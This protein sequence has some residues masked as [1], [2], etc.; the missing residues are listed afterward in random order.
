MRIDCFASSSSGNLYRVEDGKTTLL[1]ECGLPLQKIKQALNFRLSEIKSCLLSHS[2]ADHSRAALYLMRSG[3]DCYMSQETA[4]ALGV[5][6][7]HRL[8]VME[9]FFTTRIGTWD[10]VAFDTQHDCPGSLGFL[11]ASKAGK[12]LF[13]TDSYYCRYRFKGLTNIMIE[14]NYSRDTLSPDVHP[15]VKKRLLS[16]HM[17]LE[18][19][20][21]FFS[22][23]DLS[24]VREIILIHLSEGNSDAEMFRREVERATGRPVRVARK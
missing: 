1:I 11:L 10:V 9:P 22:A 20:L 6:G 24:Q 13:L 21:K 14:C 4:E 3:I 19:A 16:S 12:L 23:N 7:E 5:Q 15:E 2:H 18:N 8:H 17:S